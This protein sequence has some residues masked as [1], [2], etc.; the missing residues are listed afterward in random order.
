[1]ATLSNEAVKTA[2]IR[3]HFVRRTNAFTLKDGLQTGLL[4]EDD[5]SRSARKYYLLLPAEAAVNGWSE[6]DKTKRRDII[7]RHLE[8]VCD[9]NSVNREQVKEV[10][11]WLTT[12]DSVRE[13]L[14][15]Y[16]RTL[17]Q[18]F[19]RFCFVCGLQIEGTVSVDHIFPFSKGG[20]TDIRNMILVHPACNSTKGASLPGEL[21]RWSPESITTEL[22][23]VRGKLRYAIFLRDGFTCTEADCSMGLFTRTEIS[24]RLSNYTGI[25]CYDNLRTVCTAC[26]AD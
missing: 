19:G 24:L 4:G 9:E 25:A 2:E 7:R 17:M 1:M 6:L 21:M 8:S 12:R 26:S 10:D 3:D 22:S 20:E 11:I 15:L 23:D 16:G 13:R 5:L 14:T 18:R